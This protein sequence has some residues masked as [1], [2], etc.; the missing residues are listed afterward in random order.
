M[1]IPTAQQLQELDDFTIRQES[2]AS[3]DLMERA[4]TKVAAAIRERWP[5]ETPVTIFA[6]PGNN[7]GDALAV[8]RLLAETG[9]KVETFLFNTNGKLSPDCEENKERLKKLEG[10]SFTEITSQFEP[11]RL[12]ESHL[13]VDGLFGTGLNKPLNGGFASLV[14]LINASPAK[15][16]SIDMP[17][18]LMCEDNTYNIP[19]H[20]ICAGLTLTFQLPKLAMLLA[21]NQKYIGELQILDIGLSKEKIE[22]IET[23]FSITEEEVIKNLLRERSPFGHKGTFGHSL[24]IAGKYGMAGAAVLAAQACL[25]SG[26]GKVTIHTPKRNN[27]ILQTCVPEAILDHDNDENIFTTPIDT[28]PYDAMAIGPGIGTDRNTAIAFIEQ[29]SRSRIPLLIDADGLN[30]LSGHKGWMQQIPRECILTPHPAELK[31][32]GNHCTDS[33]TTLAEAR[34]MA[35]RHKIYI[36]LKGHFTAICTPTGKTFF[37]PTGNSGMATA[38]SGDVLSG[39]ITALLAGKYTQEEACLLGV[40][41]HGLAGDLA[42]AELGEDSMTASDI[43][44]YLPQAF[45]TLRK[46]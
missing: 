30:I 37:N 8:A 3:V 1:K 20:I 23:G 34:E 6:G 18:G 45:R 10:T 36:I 14:K 2:I 43:I 44:R 46:Q 12:T 22:E 25:R 28:E 21:D 16:V 11:P 15:V 7:G 4:A 41:V 40:Y 26:A 33:Y 9:Y 38:G 42:A 24:L 39:I 31:R 19:N 5:L 27:D 29:V 17:S 32:M 35:C 13:V